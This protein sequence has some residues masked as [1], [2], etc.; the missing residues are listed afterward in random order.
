M[1]LY[2]CLRLHTLPPVLLPALCLFDMTHQLNFALLDEFFSCRVRDS[3]S[4]NRPRSDARPCK[5]ARP[6]QDARPRTDRR[7][8]KVSKI[9]I[10]DLPVLDPWSRIFSVPVTELSTW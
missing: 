7:P 5:D 1:L 3:H 9:R 10:T 8:Q 4:N 2:R 6:R